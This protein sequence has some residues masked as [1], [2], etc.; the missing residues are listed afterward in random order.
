MEMPLT[1]NFP[2]ELTM[3]YND[4]VIAP[5]WTELN[6]REN[7]S[8]FYR[9]SESDI[10]IKRVSSDINRT[11]SS[12]LFSPTIL[13][14]TTWVDGSNR[15]GQVKCYSLKIQGYA[16]TIKLL[17]LVQCYCIIQIWLLLILSII[18]ILSMYL[19]SVKPHFISTIL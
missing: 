12:R 2:E 15:N 5:Y 9:L 1:D 10:D 18:V 16:E 14:I 7:T 4:H 13:L 3:N 19:F 17:K 6:P 11:F 8:V